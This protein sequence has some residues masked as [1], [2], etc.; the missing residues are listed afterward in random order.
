VYEYL[1]LYCVSKKIA[2]KIQPTFVSPPSSLPSNISHCVSNLRRLFL[3]RF[4]YKMHKQK[5]ST[6]TTLLQNASIATRV[7]R[8]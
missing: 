1:R 8:L 4:F 2:E 3:G 6:K 7:V 5:T